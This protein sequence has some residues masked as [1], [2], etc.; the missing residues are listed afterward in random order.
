MLSGETTRFGLVECRS[1]GDYSTEFTSGMNKREDAAMLI[2]LALRLL[3][4]AQQQAR[5]VNLRLA[6]SLVRSPV[7]HLK[8]GWCAAV[9]AACP[10]MESPKTTPSA[11]KPTPHTI[12]RRP[13]QLRS[14][15]DDKVFVLTLTAVIY[16]P[17]KPP[18]A[19]TR[20]IHSSGA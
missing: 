8:P 9:A 1:N 16:T 3:G 15:S 5:R 20:M 17:S 14:P 4:F 13:L 7:P 12:N 2:D 6:V 18:N 19:S 10:G 11:S